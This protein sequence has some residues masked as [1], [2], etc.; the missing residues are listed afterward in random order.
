MVLN[1]LLIWS[2]DFYMYV[3]L[4]LRSIS[5]PGSSY[6]PSTASTTIWSLD[7]SNHS[8]PRQPLGPLFAPSNT[9]TTIR[10][11]GHSDQYS[12]SSPHKPLFAPSTTRAAIRPV[13]PI[14]HYSP[15]H[16]HGP[17]LAPS[18]PRT[19]IRPVNPTDHFQVLWRMLGNKSCKLQKNYHPSVKFWLLL[20][21]SS[22]LRS[23][24]PIVFRKKLTFLNFH[25]LAQQSI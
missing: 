18:I 7:R 2:L 20:S 12:L 4:K 16:P 5:L 25:Q 17:L 11:V 1:L 24:F 15:R 6:F 14:D 22:P 9:R 3:T 10:P 19:T 21:N 8:S 13:D 23:S